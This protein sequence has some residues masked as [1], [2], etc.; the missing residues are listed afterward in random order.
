MRLLTFLLVG[1]LGGSLRPLH[2]IGKQEQDLETQKLMRN[3]INASSPGFTVC[4]S[5]ISFRLRPSA[6]VVP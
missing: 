6:D 2:G 1:A 3:K 5:Y 4:L